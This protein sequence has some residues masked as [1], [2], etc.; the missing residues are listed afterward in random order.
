MLRYAY[1]TVIRD[2]PELTRN[3]VPV[4][5]FSGVTLSAGL[6]NRESRH[7]PVQD[8]GSCCVEKW[9]SL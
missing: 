1:G 7:V 4:S 5:A 2:V 3:D 8:T 9:V 6:L